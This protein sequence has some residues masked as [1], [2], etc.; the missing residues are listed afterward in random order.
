MAGFNLNYASRHAKLKSAKKIYMRID[1]KVIIIY[2]ANMFLVSFFT[3][4]P[5][6]WTMLIID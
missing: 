6:E 1:S 3:D 2:S 5:V 4:Q